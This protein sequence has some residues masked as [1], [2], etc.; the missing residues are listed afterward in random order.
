LSPCTGETHSITD[1][2]NRCIAR[3]DRI[4]D[5]TCAFADAMHTGRE[6]LSLSPDAAPIS[7]RRISPFADCL[8]TITA[9]T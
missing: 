9:S 8:S 4:S 3:A 7:K 6:T 1:A 2:M 5:E